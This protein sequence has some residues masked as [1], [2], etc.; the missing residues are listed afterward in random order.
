ME[1][2]LLDPDILSEVLKYRDA[3]VVHNAAVYFQQH[4]A[5]AFS[6]MS[7][8]EV[9]RGLVERRAKSQLQRF[10][11]FCRNNFILP[12]T[13]TIFDRAA[14]LWAEARQAGHSTNDADMI[15]AATA[16]ESRRVLI[17]GNHRHFAWISQL[18]LDDWRKP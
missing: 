9:L 4:G 11:L 7:R 1:L 5:F 15:I 18:K 2:S 8:Y 6:S 16:L 14:D 13:D 17:T 12:I 3:R 10:Q